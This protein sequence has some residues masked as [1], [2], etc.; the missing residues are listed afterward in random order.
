MKQKQ[1]NKCL[2]VTLF[3]VL[4]FMAAWT[5]YPQYAYY[6]GKN[7][8]ITQ[9]YQWQHVQTA[10]FDLYYY[11]R[12]ETLIKKLAIAS[13]KAYQ[14]I[15]DY[16][17]VKVKKR[18][19]LIFYSTH[20]DFEMN[21]IAGYLPPQVQAFAESN[22]N[23]VVVQ[24]DDTFDELV[25][26]I[27]HELGHIFEY[28]LIGNRAR[29]FSPPLWFMEGFSEF[30]THHW[31]PFSLLTVRDM[32][33]TGRIPVMG[34]SGE[35]E[36]PYYNGRTIPYDF[37][38]MIY[39]FLDEKFGKRGIKKF[40]YSARG[41]SLF[42][43]KRDLL[44]VFDYTPKLFNYEFGK[45]LRNRF[46]PFFTKED[47]EDYSYI[48]GPDL[49][50]AYTFSHQVSPSGE[51]VAILTVNYKMQQLNILLISMKDGK[52][53]KNLTPG[54]TTS[55]D[56]ISLNFNPTDGL[57][58]TW[59]RESD[60]IAFF[61]RKE[62]TDYLVVIDVLTGKTQ[63]MIK[64]ENIQKATSPKFNPKNPKQLYFAGQVDTKSYIYS[65]DIDTGKV[66]RHTDGLLFI[67][68]FDI[69][70][71]NTRV[72]FSAKTGNYFKLY[73][74]TLDKPEMAKQLTSGDYNDI[75]PTFSEDTTR[76]YYS[77]DERQSYNICALDLNAKKMNR[78]TDVKTGNFFPI[79]IPG[80]KNFVVMSSYYKGS[81][82]LFKKDISTPQEERDIQFSEVD[83]TTLAK[84][85]EQIAGDVEVKFMGKYRPLKK[86]F[87]DSLPPIAVSVGTDGG[88]NGYS[89]L[90]LTDL[91]GD[92][93]FSMMV[94]TFYGYR[95]YDL[96]YLNQKRRFQMYSHLFA[97]K[98]VYYYDGYNYANYMTL[99]SKY[100]GEFG[101]FYPFSRSYRAEATVSL[102]KQKENLD[103]LNYGGDLPYGQFFDGTAL[104]LRLSLVGETT[105]FQNYGPNMG[106]SF[107]IS[108]S[109]YVKIGS[110]FLDAYTLEADFRKYLRISNT[111]LLAFRLYGYKSGGKNSLL[112]WSGGNNTFRSEGFYRLTGNNIFLF[113]AEFRF[114]LVHAALTP[115][116]II[117]PVRGVFFFDV[118]GIWY[119]GEKFKLFQE[120]AEG[121]KQFRLQDAISVYGYGL[122]FFL[123]GYPMHVEWV[124][125]TDWKYKAYHGVN[126]WIGF[127]F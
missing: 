72:V 107:K 108:A 77:S 35:L 122:E 66:T 31:D 93:V 9:K 126:F 83:T 89:Y 117:G 2:G 112:F 48:I 51:L 64:L 68:A 127:D 109:K 25:R 124:W 10:H 101:F 29:F 19:P 119:N 28:T 70:P 32:V 5:A 82:T 4:I 55:Y 69:T 59:N 123:F 61:V 100:G 13:E 37:G 34:K 125:K 46:K 94:A 76:I 120:N 62:W 49:P 114:P 21:N 15:S 23:R 90:T 110:K 11:H 98:D 54:I 22:S 106:H 41:G 38:H 75:T 36:T 102:Y 118:G 78:F 7:K 80:E 85:D 18:I 39:E 1:I 50:F 103:N 104:P 87:V 57:S 17:N 67:K 79:E 26:T 56:S 63:K 33:L 96:A 74:G 92:H 45:Y 24:G 47:P 121:K 113:N 27:T 91:L 6:Y 116:G 97:Y 53:I 16:L 20:I 84:I 111:A 115:I 99:R 52:V 14:N 95:S 73:L 105:L 71:D 42:K 30:V 40:L 44:S 3:L 12:Q 81:F 60:Q 86:L 65:M 88:F 8:V 58:F 43:G